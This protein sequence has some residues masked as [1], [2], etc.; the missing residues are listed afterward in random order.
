M[1]RLPETILRKLEQLVDS[2]EKING[3]SM[4]FKNGKVRLY[5]VDETVKVP[6]EIDGYPVEFVVVGTPRLL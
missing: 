2:N 4:G 3:Y 5:T 1:T 6:T